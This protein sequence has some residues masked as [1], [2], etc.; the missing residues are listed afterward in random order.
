MQLTVGG[1]EGIDGEGDRVVLLAQAVIL[2]LHRAKVARQYQRVAD[3]GK[4]AVQRGDL[5]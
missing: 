3:G 4:A 2:V 1:A 5:G